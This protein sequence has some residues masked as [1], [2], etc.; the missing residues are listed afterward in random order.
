MLTYKNTYDG[1]PIAAKNGLRL[2]EQ[3]TGFVVNAASD[4]VFINS[5]NPSLIKGLL[6]APFF[7]VQEVELSGEKRKR[8]VGLK[9]TIPVGALLVKNPRTTN[10]LSKIISLKGAK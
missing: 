6:S 4:R 7:E 2:E 9:G 1:E 5:H 10:E 8:V 3:E